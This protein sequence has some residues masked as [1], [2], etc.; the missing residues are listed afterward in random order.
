MQHLGTAM[1]FH[2]HLRILLREY[3]LKIDFG[4]KDSEVLPN[5]CEILNT[6]SVVRRHY[7]APDNTDWI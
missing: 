4:R 5:L 7:S 3:E 6:G 1:H 2:P